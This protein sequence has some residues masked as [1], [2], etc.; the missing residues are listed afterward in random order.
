MQP[1]V[2]L[3]P[4][5]SRPRELPGHQGCGQVLA[6]RVLDTPGRVA[7]LPIITSKSCHHHLYP[8]SSE[9]TPAFPAE[10]SLQLQVPAV[11]PLCEEAGVADGG[12]VCLQRG[13]G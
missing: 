7:L 12:I 9:Q 8:S 6:L 10:T 2:M 1:E 3:S 13:R 4:L 5:P 11:C